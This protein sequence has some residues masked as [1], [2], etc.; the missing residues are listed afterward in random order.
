VGPEHKIKIWCSSPTS[1]ACSVRT[2]A[3]HP[4]GLIPLIIQPI[5]LV[6]SGPD[7]TDGA[8]DLSRA[9]PS[10]PN[11]IRLAGSASPNSLVSMLKRGEKGP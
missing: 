11:A 3:R 5:R 7:A 10:N 4:R 9:G 8:P 1:P 2:R 6:P